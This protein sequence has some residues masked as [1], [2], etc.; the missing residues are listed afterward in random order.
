MV[1]SPVFLSV[2]V[3]VA[4]LGHNS[5]LRPCGSRQLRMGT[6][7]WGT[8]RKS[9]RARPVS[10]IRVPHAQAP[11]GRPPRDRHRRRKLPHSRGHAASGA[12]GRP[13]RRAETEVHIPS[14]GTHA[15][16]TSHHG[17]HSRHLSLR[18]HPSSTQLS[19]LALGDSCRAVG[20]RARVRPAGPIRTRRSASWGITRTRRVRSWRRSAT[21]K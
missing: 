17:V 1:P 9:A 15:A 5:P 18:R 7:R 3:L 6:S 2:C 10:T 16:W 19:S 11:C 14:A 4:T 12:L 8:L 21:C 20:P 13:D